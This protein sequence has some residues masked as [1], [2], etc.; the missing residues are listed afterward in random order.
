M[1]FPMMN[2]V[3]PSRA[4]HIQLD[5]MWNRPDATRLQDVT[6]HYVRNQF[7]DLDIGRS[8]A[9]SIWS[10]LLGRN[11]VLRQPNSWDYELVWVVKHCKVKGFRSA[12]YKLSLAAAIYHIW[13]ERNSRVFT[14]KCSS[15]DLVVKAIVAKIRDRIL[16]V[17]LAAAS[18]LFCCAYGEAVV[19]EVGSEI[20]GEDKS[21]EESGGRVPRAP[22]IH[23]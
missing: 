8:Y 11:L 7:T 14:Q 17:G 23:Q 3:K 9:K 20:E 12:I 2:V 19:E 22:R 16:G 10:D 15:Q 21:E 13:L 5:M 4:Y 6:L 18:L 1:L